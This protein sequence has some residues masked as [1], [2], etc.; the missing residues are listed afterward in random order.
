[1]GFTN[2]FSTIKGAS[3]KD[4]INGH[5]DE[6]NYY[7]EK[8]NEAKKQA[9][10]IS[11]LSNE[12]AEKEKVLAIIN[13]KIE[14][15]NTELQEAVDKVADMHSLHTEKLGAINESQSELANKEKE[16][17]NSISA[18]E[19]LITTRQKDLSEVIGKVLDK[20]NELT[21]SKKELE[22]TKNLVKEAKN[23]LSVALSE[24][25]KAENESKDIKFETKEQSDLLIRLK[26]GFDNLKKQG[27]DEYAKLQAK[28]FELSTVEAKLLE[29]KE[30]ET[31]I[32][33]KNEENLKVYEERMGA[34]SLKEGMLDDRHK[35]LIKIKAE[36]EKERGYA[37]KLNI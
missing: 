9:E 34:C 23:V 14:N 13:S 7:V 25:E 15:K 21:A 28:K 33:S 26:V 6:L 29:L 1:M 3:N 10:S 12:I 4:E 22:D 27:D 8:V 37:I 20:M 19:K 30:E 11:D 31:K 24:K 36:L 5:L 2:R 18:F 17:K 32:S 16:M 35:K